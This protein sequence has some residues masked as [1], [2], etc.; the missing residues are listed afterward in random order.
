MD[1]EIV[2]YRPNYETGVVQ[3]IVCNNETC[4]S[5]LEATTCTYKTKEEAEGMLKLYNRMVKKNEL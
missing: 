2:M 1:K 4:A 5:I 3:K